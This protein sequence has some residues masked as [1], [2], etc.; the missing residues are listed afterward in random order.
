M[1]DDTGT[2]RLGNPMLELAA[3]TILP[4]MLR[5]VLMSGRFVEI[6]AF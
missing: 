1:V 3:S 2:N 4:E 6:V 5:V